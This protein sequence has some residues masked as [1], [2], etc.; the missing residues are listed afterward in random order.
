M[1]QP[2][3]LAFAIDTLE[4]LDITYMVV[5]SLASGAYGEPRM[6]QDIDIVIQATPSKV[7]LLCADRMGLAEIWQD[8]LSRLTS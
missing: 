8:I 3:L 7:E 6:T 5:G 1:E 4:R 2:D